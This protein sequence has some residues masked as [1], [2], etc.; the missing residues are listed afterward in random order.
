[1]PSC[2]KIS[3]VNLAEELQ[4]IYDSEI[5]V[6]IS[7]LWDGGIDVWLG[8]DMNGYVAEDKVA[9]VA[10]IIPWLQE[11]I[12]HF[13]PSS[14]YASGLSVEIRDHAARRLFQAPRIGASVRCPH[15]GAPQATLM[16]EVIAFVCPQ[17]GNS[18]SVEPPKV[19]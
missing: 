11:A 5:N 14:T 1:M 2:A 6:R 19:Q 10:E 13:Y 7:W 15:C 18:V 12:A 17:C 16:D 8:D 3:F 4:K 9:S